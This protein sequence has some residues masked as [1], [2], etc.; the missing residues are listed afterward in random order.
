M[1]IFQTAKTACTLN[2]IHLSFGGKSEKLHSHTST[3]TQTHRQ[4]HP[5]THLQVTLA[6]NFSLF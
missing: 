4:R 6:Q 1:F 2:S 3:H 5:Y